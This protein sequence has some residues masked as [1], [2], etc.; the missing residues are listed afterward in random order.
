MRIASVVPVTKVVLALWLV[1]PPAFAQMA[2]PKDALDGVDAVALLDQGKEISGKPEFKASRGKFDY[3]F[4]TAEN[5]ATFE[6]NPE[7]YEIQLSGACA[8]MGG[9]VTGNPADYAVV[10]G[11]IYI[12]GSDDCHKKFVA[13]PAKFLPKPAP[14]MP[15]DARAVQAGR[16]LLD[17]AVA[18]L[19]GAARVDAVASY[20]ETASQTQTRPQGQVTL[21]LKT[22]RRFPGEVRVER[23]MAMGDRTQTTAMLITPDGGWFISG[24]RAF[25]QNPEGRTVNEQEYGRALLPMLRARTAS[26]FK[27]VAVASA[28]VDG[29]A[30]DRVR[31]K[32]RL[33][34]VTIGL[35]KRTGQV[36]SLS[37]V[38]RNGEAEIGDYT[39]ILSD[40][41]DVDGLRLPFSERATFNGQPDD[42]R[43]RTITAFAINPAIDAALFKAPAT[44][45]Q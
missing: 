20:I 41:R 14:A 3:L 31:I 44:G 33:V 29:V 4:A 26:G 2:Q 1:A 17:K 38:G 45:G 40:Y 24:P 39:I 5:K 25:P 43:T 28:I 7:K 36:H 37:F 6:K 18:S 27:A 12:F 13:A 19:G 8:R 35:D 23:T 9:G 11:R 32:D 10:D 15:T 34:D 21:A 30:E 42:F 22:I 16:A